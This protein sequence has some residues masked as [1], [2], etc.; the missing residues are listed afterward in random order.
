MVI[1][2]RVNICRLRFRVRLNIVESP[3]PSDL[4]ALT[5]GQDLFSFLLENTPDQVYFKDLQGRFLRASRAVARY[6]DVAN[7]LDLIGKSDFDFWS[8]ANGQRGVLT[9]SS[10]SSR[11]GNR[12]WAKWRN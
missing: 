3:P 10:V 7:P 2:L 1:E 9:T 8:A 12:W 6:M 4:E 5:L 11:P